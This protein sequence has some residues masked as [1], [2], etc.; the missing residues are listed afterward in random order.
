MDGSLSYV[1]LFARVRCMAVDVAVRGEV[2]DR[3][4]KADLVVVLA[5]RKRHGDA[6]VGSIL[7]RDSLCHVFMNALCYFL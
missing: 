2:H 7:I 6:E 1:L 5:R 3:R 4:G